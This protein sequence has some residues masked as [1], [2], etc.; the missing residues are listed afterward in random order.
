MRREDVMRCLAER[1]PGWCT[2]AEIADA[3]VK[4]GSREAV[5][6]TKQSVRNKLEGYLKYGMVERIPD[7]DRMLYRMVPTEG[8]E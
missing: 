6:R 2:V 1:Y 7:G 8:S 4:D 5:L 3:F